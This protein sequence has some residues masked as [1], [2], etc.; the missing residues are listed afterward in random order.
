MM[1]IRSR[2]IEDPDRRVMDRIFHL[3][4]NERGYHH[5]N[6]LKQDGTDLK[7]EVVGTILEVEL[8]KPLLPGKNTKLSMT[9]DSQVPLQVRRTG[10]DNKEGQA[11]FKMRRKL[12]MAMRINL[13]LS[14]GK[15]EKN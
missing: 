4:E 9:F 2:T 6:E 1:D 14:K 8:A 10:R 3:A 13:S 12:G 5:I 15:K 11:T 7:Y